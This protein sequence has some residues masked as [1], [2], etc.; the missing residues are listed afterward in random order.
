MATVHV[1]CDECGEE[2]DCVFYND[3]DGYFYIKGKCRNCGKEFSQ[4]L[5]GEFIDEEDEEMQEIDIEQISENFERL[6]LE[7]ED[8]NNI[9]E[10]YLKDNHKIYLKYPCK[11]TKFEW[12][13]TSNIDKN[14]KDRFLY[15]G[16]YECTLDRIE[17]LLKREE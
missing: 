13:V 9:Y 11:E 16:D 4:D 2:I 1:I 17:E 5:K 3:Y 10:I 15:R 14:F 7:F 12:E 8:G 6:G